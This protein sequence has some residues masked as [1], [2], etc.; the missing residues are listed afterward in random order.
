MTTHPLLPICPRKNKQGDGNEDDSKEAN[1]ACN[2]LQ[3][4]LI[5]CLNNANDSQ[6]IDF[7]ASF[8]YFQDYVQGDFGLVYLGDD[9]PCPFVGNK[10]IKI[11]FPNGNDQML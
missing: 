7:G 6:V 2:D 4:A 11:K 5:L 9:E 3:D 8:Q 1:V 10:K